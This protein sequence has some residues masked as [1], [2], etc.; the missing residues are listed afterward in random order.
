M[1][2]DLHSALFSTCTAYEPL[3][4]TRLYHARTT[5]LDPLLRRDS[6]SSTCWHGPEHRTRDWC[7]T[8]PLPLSASRHGSSRARIRGGLLTP[9][10]LPNHGATTPVD[11]SS[12]V[13]PSIT[14]GAT[15]DTHSKTGGLCSPHPVW[16]SWR[17]HMRGRWLTSATSCRGCAGWSGSSRRATT[18]CRC[19][20]LTRCCSGG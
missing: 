11:T 18:R 16:C 1:W 3:L 10:D 7:G 4:S 5:R 13:R 8:T 20:R 6:N 15:L 2:F 9:T 12:A 17:G 14:A 19:L